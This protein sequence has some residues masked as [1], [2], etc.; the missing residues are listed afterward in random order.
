MA[1]ASMMYSWGL[2]TCT[3]LGNAFAAG[4]TTGGS[5]NLWKGPRRSLLS[6]HPLFL[7]CPFVVLSCREAPLIQLGALGSAVSSPCG[8]NRQMLFLCIL[9]KKSLLVVIYTY[10]CHRHTAIFA[11]EI[12][13]HQSLAIALLC[14]GYISLC[15]LA[16]F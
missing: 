11:R 3:T 16:S 4:Y 8:P 14:V 10:I 5:R 7:P 6:V 1:H 12:Y 2:D 9:S 15:H 13:Y